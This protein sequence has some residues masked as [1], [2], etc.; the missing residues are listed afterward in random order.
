MSGRVEHSIEEERLRRVVHFITYKI[1][2]CQSCSNLMLLVDVSHEWAIL[3]DYIQQLK[4][5]D[6]WS[7][8]KRGSLAPQSL[9]CD[10]SFRSRI[11][12][13]L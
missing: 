13:C 8:A 2:S 7:L 3:V 4:E 6:Q 11:A 12:K 5:H 1:L 9:A 10:G